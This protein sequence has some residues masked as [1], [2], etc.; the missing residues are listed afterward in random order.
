MS[1]DDWAN[2][3][4]VFLKEFGVEKPD[5]A[6]RDVFEKIPHFERLNP[7]LLAAAFY[8]SINNEF[9]SDLSMNDK[10]VVFNYRI[11]IE[12]E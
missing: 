11:R 9:P 1:L 2:K 7:R 12:T 10:I 6:K 4:S 3:F 5:E 8:L